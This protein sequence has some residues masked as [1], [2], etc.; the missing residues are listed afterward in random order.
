MQEINGGRV[1]KKKGATCSS[2]L[3]G[4]CESECV[5]LHTESIESHSL[6]KANNDRKRNN[7]ETEKSEQGKFEN[8]LFSLD[9]NFSDNRTSC[10]IRSIVQPVPEICLLLSVLRLAAITQANI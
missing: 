3:Q 5:Y 6:G 2:V 8:T 7:K 10:K 1:L 4:N 9:T